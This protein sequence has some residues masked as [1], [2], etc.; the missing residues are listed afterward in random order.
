MGRRRDAWG[1]DGID[2]I[3]VELYETLEETGVTLDEL[4]KASG[5]SRGTFS[6]NFRGKTLPNIDIVRRLATALGYKL[7]L[8][9]MS[10]SELDAA[11]K[12][13]EDK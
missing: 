11:I 13:T 10:E 5:V 9:K 8:V 3:L 1:C 4:A 2:P 7:V 6:D 12:G